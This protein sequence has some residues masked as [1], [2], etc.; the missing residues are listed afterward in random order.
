MDGHTVIVGSGPTGLSAA[1]YL[2]SEGM[3]VTV[4]DR[5]SELVYDRY[6][7]ICGAGI[8]A[9]T[10][11]KL[12]YI[13]PTDIRNTIEYGELSF[14]GDIQVRIPVK[15]Y[16]LDRVAFLHR[17]KEMCI[18]KGC[19]FVHGAVVDVVRD[20]DG[21]EVTTRGGETFHCTHVIGCDGA[22]SIVR[23]RLFGWRPAKMIPT[24]ECIVSGEPRPVFRM[25]LGE[26][27]E[28]AYS[29]T[30]PAGDDVSIGALK[31]LV[32][33]EG[34]ISHG[35]RMIPF[36]GGGHIEDG[37]AYLCG[38]AAAMANPICAGGLM[39]GL[40]SAQVCAKS[41]LSGKGGKYQKWWDDSI[42]SSYR[43]MDFHRTICSWKDSDFED[44]AEPFRGGRNFYLSGMKALITKPHYAREYIGCLQTFRHAW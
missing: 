21:F 34:A 20:D 38:D 43:F 29:W 2:S 31:N 44:A 6:H 36:G 26:R 27:W 41:I 8:S 42:L 28:G 32:S 14:P 23:K 9:K 40:L 22:H 25:E 10:F 39:V 18:S 12:K 37:G 3:R 13:E 5:M 1:L 24:T 30:F 11:R 19:T 15:G 4:I 16:V 7:E 33:T 17:L 35:S